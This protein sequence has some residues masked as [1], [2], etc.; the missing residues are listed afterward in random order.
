MPAEER[1]IAS[2]EERAASPV[3]NA[4]C[5]VGCVLDSRKSH[6]NSPTAALADAW[7]LPSLVPNLPCE[8]I[9]NISM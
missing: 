5:C 6:L 7:L 3:E 4:S 8:K 9:L 2:E 1:T